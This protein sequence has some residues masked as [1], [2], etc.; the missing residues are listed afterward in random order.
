MAPKVFCST[1]APP[2]TSSTSLVGQG[3]DPRLPR[4]GT[5]L[6]RDFNGQAI[7]VTVHKDDFEWQ[8]KR[9]RSLSAI[10]QAATG[11]RWNGF[12][13]FGLTAPG[14]KRGR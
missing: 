8:N 7:I 10:A 14:G 11:T 2:P 4:P 13:F 12:V 9:Y 3:R 1:V 6:K 5:L